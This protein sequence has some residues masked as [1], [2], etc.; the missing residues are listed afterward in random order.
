MKLTPPR[1]TTDAPK[2]GTPIVSGMPDRIPKGPLSVAVPKG[3]DQ[4]SRR[5]FKSMADNIP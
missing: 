4:S 1:V 5:V 3:L 2:L